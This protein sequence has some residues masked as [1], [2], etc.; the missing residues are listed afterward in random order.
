M[1]D[2]VIYRSSGQSMLCFK[3][4][5]LIV[6]PKVFGLDEVGDSCSVLYM[7]QLRPKEVK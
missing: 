1:A 3:G 5:R 4:A 6:G 7:R 2:C